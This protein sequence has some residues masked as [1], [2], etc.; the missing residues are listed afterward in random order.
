MSASLVGSEMCIRDR[1]TPR[2]A[3]A[4]RRAPSSLRIRLATANVLSLD[5]SPK[6]SARASQ[7]TIPT[8]RMAQLQ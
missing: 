2:Q 3:S 8:G 6:A 7:S 5:T 4:T 1:V